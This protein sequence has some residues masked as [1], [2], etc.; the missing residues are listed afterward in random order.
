MYSMVVS[1]N[2]DGRLEVFTALNSADSGGG[3]YHIWQTAPN[4]GWSDWNPI[5]DWEARPGFSSIAVGTNHPS[6]RLELFVLD[7]DSRVRRTWQQWG[8]I[9]PNMVWVP[10]GYLGTPEALNVFVAG[11]PNSGRLEVFSTKSEFLP[12]ENVG[13]FRAYH[14]WQ[15]DSEIKHPDQ[16]TDHYWSNLYP[17]GDDVVLLAV[18]ENLDTKQLEAFGTRN[19]YVYHSYQIDPDTDFNWSKWEPL[20]PPLYPRKAKQLTTFKN[21]KQQRLELFAVEMDGSVWRTWRE[22]GANHPWHPWVPL[23][24]KVFG[25]TKVAVEQNLDGRLELFGIDPGQG[26]IHCYEDTPGGNFKPWTFMGRERDIEEVAVGRNADGRLEVFMTESGGNCVWH[27]WQTAPD[28]VESWFP[29]WD[30]LAFH[31]ATHTYDLDGWNPF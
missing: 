17:F 14:G 13:T 25:W 21:Q 16:E 22:E 27:T 12:G 5:Y 2:Q 1:S 18:G 8:Q 31:Q 20:Y 24:A 28:G 10:A 23:G 26:L 3:V 6:G 19:Y 15:I 30:P 9:A 7:K 4:N 29:N 11:N